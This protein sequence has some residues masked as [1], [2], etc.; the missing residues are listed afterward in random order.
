MLEGRESD[1]VPH[2]AAVRRGALD[3]DHAAI[4]RQIRLCGKTQHTAGLANRTVGGNP[5]RLTAADVRVRAKT[6]VRSTP[7]SDLLLERQLRSDLDAGLARRAVVIFRA[8]PCAVLGAD[9]SQAQVD[10]LATAHGF[11]DP[12]RRRRLAVQPDAHAQSMNAAERAATVGSPW[13]LDL[14]VERLGVLGSASQETR[15]GSRENEGG[16][17]VRIVL[18]TAVAVGSLERVETQIQIHRHERPEVPRLEP[19]VVGG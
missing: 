19:F 10:R 13:S 17:V 14:P 3:L 7:E 18:P 2:G 9:P 12:Q 1:P 11:E 4:R 6:R 8:S 5:A 16:R 15:R